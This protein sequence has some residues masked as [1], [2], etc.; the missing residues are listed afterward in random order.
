MTIPDVRNQNKLESLNETMS[1]SLS[2][3]S[4]NLESEIDD[5]RDTTIKE[6]GQKLA[7][8]TEKFNA[9]KQKQNE[10]SNLVDN[11]D[12][13]LEVLKINFF[14]QYANY[15]E[16]IRIESFHELTNKSLNMMNNFIIN[17]DEYKRIVIDRMQ[18]SLT[19]EVSKLKLLPVDDNLNKV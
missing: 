18:N 6:V 8:L 1:F 10:L 3:I 17:T 15:A 19:L 4:N 9:L 13:I 14:E 16:S 2:N 12:Q 5:L 11:H 7:N